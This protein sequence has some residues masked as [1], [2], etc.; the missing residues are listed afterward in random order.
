MTRADTA[1]GWGGGRGKRIQPLFFLLRGLNSSTGA[2]GHGCHHF[3]PPSLRADQGFLLTS[4]SEESRA[5]FPSP[6]RALSVISH[7]R[8]LRDMAPG[9]GPGPGGDAGVC[10]EVPACAG[11]GCKHWGSLRQGERRG[12]GEE[13]SFVFLSSFVP[14]LT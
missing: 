13:K 12:G 4:A 9:R 8:H 10:V 3:S 14:E 1:P 11:P 6:Q 5:P 7:P 2:E